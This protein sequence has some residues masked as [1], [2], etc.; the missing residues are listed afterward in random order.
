MSRFRR[1]LPVS[2][3]A[4]VLSACAGD[5]AVAPVDS[6]LLNAD[7]A[8]AMAD[9]V[10]EDVQTMRELSWGLRLG[11]M[12]LNPTFGPPRSGCPFDAGSGWH[13]CEPVELPNGLIIDREY[14]FYDAA[15]AAME[16]FDPVQTASIR[17]RRTV[18]GEF[19]RETE[20][21]SL[22]SVVHHARDFTVSGLQGEEQKRTWNGTGASQVNRTRISDQR[23]TRSYEL[24][25]DVSV[26]DVEVPAR[27]NPERDPW[28]LSGTIT[29]HATG[30]VTQDGET[31]SFERTIMITFNGTQ[32]ASVT[33]TGPDGSETFEIDLANRRVHQHR[34]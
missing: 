11:V 1:L 28:P 6:P 32:F 14:A 16:Q 31:R 23:G 20:R 7:L 8:A 34:P 18:A 15:G 22:S 24:A 29:Q 27:N 30:K 10:G 9:G 25:S 17:V 12:F 4:A 19:E 21:G 13:D 2:L 3:A 5:D 33:V 26:S